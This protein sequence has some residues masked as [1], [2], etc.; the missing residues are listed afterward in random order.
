[1]L[2]HIQNFLNQSDLDFLFNS[3]SFA[4]HSSI[5]CRFHVFLF[6]I[7]ISIVISRGL[8]PT[9]IK[10]DCQPAKPILQ[11]IVNS[12]IEAEKEISSF[13][14]IMEEKGRKFNTFKFLLQEESTLFFLFFFFKKVLN[15]SCRLIFQYSKSSTRWHDVEL[16]RKNSPC[17]EA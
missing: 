16:A 3:S 5:F 1:M 15:L 10:M 14:K 12:Q 6:H 9:I 7:P 2:S 8:I 17:Q 11:R 4:R 13:K